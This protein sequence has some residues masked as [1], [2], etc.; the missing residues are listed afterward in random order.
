[1]RP[2]TDGTATRLAEAAEHWLAS[3]EPAQR[4]RAMF[5]F[6]SDERFTWDYRPGERQGLAIG[7][8]SPAQQAA[9]FALVDAGLGERA[10]REVRSVIALEPILGA[11]ERQAGR[12]N[13]TRRDPGLYWFAVF[14]DPGA[15]EPWSWRLG[16]H[17]V[18]VQT[19]I[20]GGFVV[21]AAPSFLGANQAT[22]P[23]GPQAGAR[24]IDGEERLARALLASLT[25]EQRQLAVV[26]P[27]APPD[28]LSG[29]GRHA[30]LR[31]VPNGIRADQLD[32]AQ[33]R[34]L[35]ALIRHYLERA[36][37]DVAVAEWDRLEAAGLDPV[38][39]AWAGPDTPGEGHYYAVRGP[40]VLLEYDNTQDR[41]NHIHAVWRDPENDWGEDLLQAHYAAAHP[42]G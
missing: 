37:P 34:G 25:P 39:F 10:A 2:G 40:S 33:R 23:S 20:A 21:G 6:D 32:D 9:A 41:A 14:G 7:A 24:A 22:V 1:M 36:A 3:L 8:M 12:G 16:G 13:W 4:A 18:A 27:V 35:E 11:L 17:H 42:R 15:A 19:T 38:T 30:D 5:P 28:I 29:N 31:E 26:D